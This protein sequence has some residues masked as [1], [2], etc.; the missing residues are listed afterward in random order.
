MLVYFSGSN[1]V[2]E[3]L[4]KMVVAS[5]GDPWIGAKLPKLLFEAGL[6][7]R[8]E[9]PFSLYGG[10]ETD[11]FQRTLGKSEEGFLKMLVEKDFLS[12][13]LVDTYQE[14][15]KRFKENP[16]SRLYSQILMKFVA[17]KQIL[18]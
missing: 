2:N 10:P 18:S 1:D 4:S 7:I 5:G 15:L 17:E 6:L 16:H 8:Y 3:A 14:D 11:F 13:E 9:A 12:Q